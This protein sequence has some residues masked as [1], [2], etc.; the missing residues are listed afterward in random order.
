MVIVDWVYLW[1]V[2]LSYSTEYT[3]RIGCRTLDIMHVA[4]AKTMNYKEF[5]TNDMRQNDL[6]EAIGINTYLYP[7]LPSL[8]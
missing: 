6:A 7:A 1:E 2:V 4:A 8:A 5:Y 3:K